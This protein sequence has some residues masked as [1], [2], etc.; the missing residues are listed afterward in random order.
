MP[1][2]ISVRQRITGARLLLA[3]CMALAALVIG[4]ALPVSAQEHPPVALFS[5]QEAM[6]LARKP[7]SRMLDETTC[8]R[9][10]GVMWSRGNG[11][12]ML[13]PGGMVLLYRAGRRTPFMEVASRE[14]GVFVARFPAKPGEVIYSQVVAV[15]PETGQRQYGRK[16]FRSVCM[17]TA[18]QVGDV[19]PV[20]EDG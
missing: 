4:S 5:P 17:N 10:E 6:Q 14:D 12:S 20:K 11:R 8:E 15:D 9:I 16:D 13:R 1:G 3:P 2:C 18:V 7:L 19:V